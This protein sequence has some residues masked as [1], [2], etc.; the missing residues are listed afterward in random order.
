LDLVF[1]GDKDIQN[2][3]KSPTL[4]AMSSDDE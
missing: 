1:S 2:Y 4:I 3:D